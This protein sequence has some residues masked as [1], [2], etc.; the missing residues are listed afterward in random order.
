MLS[1]FLSG[2]SVAPPPV[3]PVPT[4]FPTIQGVDIAAVFVGKRIAGDFYDSIRVSPE[5]VL[6]G[7]LDVAGR[8]E[9]NRSLMVAA[10]EVFRTFGVQLFSPADINESDAMTELCLRINRRLIDVCCG[11]HSCPAFI[12]CYHEKFGTLCYSNAGHTPGLLRDS[13]G[14]AELASTGL[15][16]GLFSHATSE[17]PT[18]AL[19]KEASLLLVSR[20]VV[21]CE[22]NGRSGAFGLERVKDAFES[23]PGGSAR[24]LCDSVLSAIADFSGKSPVCDDRTALALVRGSG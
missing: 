23:A 12:A 5:R 20:G 9:N 21:D 2:S 4:V 14:V 22:G 19:A 15:P 3:E 8:R 16:L 10:Q 17:A 24:S 1:R 7:L 6:I 18:V 13:T 11:V